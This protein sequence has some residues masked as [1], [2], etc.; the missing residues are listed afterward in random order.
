LF[1]FFKEI[2]AGVVE[3]TMLSNKAAK[4][5]ES[6]V[7]LTMEQESYNQDILHSILKQNKKSVSKFRC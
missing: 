5:T 3:T 4:E 1:A 6:V 7:E 2:T